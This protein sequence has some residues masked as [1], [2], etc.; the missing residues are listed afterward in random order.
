MKPRELSQRII[1]GSLCFFVKTIKILLL[2][3]LVKV[4][5]VHVSVLSNNPRNH[6]SYVYLFENKEEKK[7]YFSKYTLTHVY[8]FKWQ[9]TDSST[10][11]TFSLNVLLFYFIYYYYKISTEMSKRRYFFG[12][13]LWFK[14]KIK[15]Q[16][17]FIVIITRAGF[18]KD[19]D[20]FCCI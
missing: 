8:L 15:G 11:L 4:S 17:C 16:E 6:V 20:N 5:L 2:S 1:S 12:C 14:L 9:M 18:F 10:P 13:L 19:F 3:C 7:L